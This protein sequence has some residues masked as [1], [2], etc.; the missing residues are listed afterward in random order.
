[1][2]PPVYQLLL[3]SPL[4]KSLL[5]VMEPSGYVEVLRVFPDSAPQKQP[6]P[7]VVW[8]TVVGTAYNLLAEPPPADHT[9][10]SIQI[11][12]DS[13]TNRDEVYQACRAAMEENGYLASLNFSYGEHETKRYTIS[14]DWSFILANPGSD[15]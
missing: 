6:L 12:A 2:T 1:M 9:R 7:Y 13:A 3:A 14:F 5:G 11:W 10:V 15:A 8:S 4:V